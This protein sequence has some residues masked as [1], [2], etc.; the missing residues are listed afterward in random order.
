MKITFELESSEAIKIL[1]DGK[2]IGHIFTPAGSGHDAQGS[3]QICGF[4]EAFDLWGCGIFGEKVSENTFKMKKDI[5]LLFTPYEN[6]TDGGIRNYS[7]DCCRCYS[8]PCVCEVK[9]PA[10]L[11]LEDTGPTNPFTVKRRIE[12]TVNGHSVK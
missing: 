5:Q 3:I 6:L 11:P 12:D 9:H 8:L 7:K 4:E 10:D 2:E 1:G